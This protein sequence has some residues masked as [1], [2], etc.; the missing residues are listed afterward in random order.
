VLS[1]VRAAHV[2]TQRCGKRISAAVNLQATIEEVVFSVGAALRLYD[3]DLRQLELELRE[4]P[5][6]AVGTIIEK[7]WQ[8]RNKALQRSL[9][10]VLQLQ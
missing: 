6:L 5:A 10:S 3:K 9:H 1:V 4:S 8:D 2:D 7:Q